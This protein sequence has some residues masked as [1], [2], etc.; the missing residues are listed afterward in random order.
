M[1]QRKFIHFYKIFRF[2]CSSEINEF[3]AIFWKGKVQDAYTFTMFAFVFTH[4]GVIAW[5]LQCALLIWRVI[6]VA[7]FTMIVY[8]QQL[9]ANTSISLVEQETEVQL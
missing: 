5:W 6:Y 2:R 7:D 9:P 8:K 4:V 3:T 1:N